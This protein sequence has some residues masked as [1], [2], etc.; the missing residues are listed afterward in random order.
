MEIVITIIMLLVGF[1]VVLKLTYLPLW[2]QATVYLV[3]ALFTGM[4]LKY[5]ISQSKIQIDIWI[6][7]V[8]Y[9][10]LT[11]PTIYSV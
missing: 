4:S 5:A 1:S 2:G 11:L 8:S 3:L 10:H 9:T 7:A 6:N